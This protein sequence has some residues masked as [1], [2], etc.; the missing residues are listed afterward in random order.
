M[1]LELAQ[2]LSDD[3]ACGLLGRCDCCHGASCPTEAT[4]GE[5]WCF[6]G[7]VHIQ[8]TMKVPEFSVLLSQAQSVLFPWASA[9]TMPIVN[10]FSR[11]T[12]SPVR[13]LNTPLST[14]PLIYGKA[15]CIKTGP[16]VLG[17]VSSPVL[18]NGLEA[19][20]ICCRRF[21]F[22][23]LHTV[24]CLKVQGFS[25][26]RALNCKQSHP[27]PTRVLNL[28]ITKTGGG[29]GMGGL[30][31]FSG[32][33]PQ[34]LNALQG[35]KHPHTWTSCPTQSVSRAPPCWDTQTVS[36]KRAAPGCWPAEGSRRDC[37]LSTDPGQ[38]CRVVS[39]PR[40]AA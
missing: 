3:R 19:G 10:G 39:P 34:M 31:A 27:P 26:G 6:C 11:V 8:E 14:L 4:Q 38:G 23:G 22:P 7:C 12:I 13:G 9:S 5:K 29:K 17:R 40:F 28:I 32:F 1:T 24:F 30:C 2:G 36:A 37:S 15:H 25:G 20:S 35:G 33:G 21:L 18:R 16:N